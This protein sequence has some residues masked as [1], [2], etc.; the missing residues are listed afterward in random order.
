MWPCCAISGCF[1]CLFVVD[2]GL[3]LHLYARKMEKVRGKKRE[4][5]GLR[6]EAEWYRR[7]RKGNHGL[8]D[9]LAESETCSQCAGC[10]IGFEAGSWGRIWGV[11]GEMLLRFA[12]EKLGLIYFE[13]RTEQVNLDR[14]IRH[15][16][17]TGTVGV[18]HSPGVN[19]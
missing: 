17:V 1:K 6:D 11:L 10:T 15:K 8:S 13:G 16:L 19:G 18:D 2:P 5:T 9:V 12:A 14:A 4:L 7:A 3:Y